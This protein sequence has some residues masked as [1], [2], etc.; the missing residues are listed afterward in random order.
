M[1][2]LIEGCDCTG[3]T[4]LANLLKTRDNYQL[5]KSNAPP[6]NLT[7]TQQYEHLREEYRRGIELLNT[8]DNIC[9]DRFLLGEAIYAPLKR[10]YYPDYI[11]QFEETIS[12]NTALVLLYADTDTVKSRFDGQFITEDEIPY[13]LYR[14]NKEFNLSRIRNKVK[15]D[16]GVF[17]EEEVY[18]LVKEHAR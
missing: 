13:V 1:N 15:I 11:R 18:R 7:S 16:T 9:F 2:I 4:T 5:L 17:N 12:D 3:K 6:A 14:F 10:G 8:S